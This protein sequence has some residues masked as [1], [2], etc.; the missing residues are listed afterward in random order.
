MSSTR[1]IL[2]IPCKNKRK[3]FRKQ[4]IK[5]IIQLPAQKN[6][7]R[8]GFVDTPQEGGMSPP[9]DGCLPK[10]GRRL[11]RPCFR[12]YPMWGG[13]KEGWGEGMAYLLLY[14]ERVS[15]YKMAHPPKNSS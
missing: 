11:A 12:E 1:P 10:H 15:K 3:T 6:I 14:K 2:L 7:C 8:V 13:G 9:S 4:A 5:E